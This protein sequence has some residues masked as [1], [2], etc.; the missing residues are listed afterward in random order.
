MAAFAVE[1]VIDELCQKVSMDPIEFRLLNS[2]AEGTRQV[3]GP[4]FGRVGFIETLEAAKN[5][6]HYHA[7]LEGPNR[8]RGIAA[9]YWGNG[10]GPASAIAS[11]NPD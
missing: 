10:S 2:A 8:G 4:T 9:G 3:T 6:P 7:P 5:H 1:Q 11:V